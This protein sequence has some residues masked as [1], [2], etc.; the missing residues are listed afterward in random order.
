MTDQSSDSEEEKDT[1]SAVQNRS[2][3]N[4]GVALYVVLCTDLVTFA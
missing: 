1:P 2:A 3:I 4:F